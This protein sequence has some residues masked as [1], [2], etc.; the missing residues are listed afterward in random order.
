[1]PAQLT[2]NLWYAQSEFFHTNSG[3]FLSDGQALLID[4]CMRPEEIDA[5]GG[6]VAAQ[7]AVPRWLVLTHS[8]W[9]HILGPERLRGVRTL[10]QAEYPAAVARDREGIQDQVAEWE[11][12]L[13]RRREAPFAPPLPD[14]TFVDDYALS[15][16]GLSLRLLHVPGHAPDQLAAYEPAGGCLWA[17]DILSDL[18][19]PFVSHDLG[20]YERTLARLETLRLDV[21]VPGHG[22]PTTE[23][24]EIRVRLDEDRAYLAELRERV[25]RAVTQGLGPAEAVALCADM[26]YRRRGENAEPHKLNVESAYLALGGQ[27]DARELGWR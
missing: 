7:G 20:A 1:M 3:I 15:L 16:G 5:L 19:I 25:T 11:A 9:D 10:A 14:E 23:P 12:R 2:P 17:S 27:G 18:E 24:A 6:W 8:H 13:G 4:P 26:A 21:L 22:H